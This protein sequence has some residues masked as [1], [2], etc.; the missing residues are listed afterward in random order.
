MSIPQ[1]LQ[2]GQTDCASITSRNRAL[3]GS[4]QSFS[5]RVIR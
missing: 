5:I 2:I 4:I 1:S 3:D